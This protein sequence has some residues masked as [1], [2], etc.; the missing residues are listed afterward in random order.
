MSFV[1][2]SNSSIQNHNLSLEIIGAD[3]FVKI[4]T[5]SRESMYRFIFINNKSIAVNVFNIPFYIHDKQIGSHFFIIMI[6]H[7]KKKKIYL[8]NQ[9]DL[10]FNDI[11]KNTFAKIFERA[12]EATEY[13]FSKSDPIK[14]MSSKDKKKLSDMSFQDK[15][16]MI[17]QKVESENS[18]EKKCIVM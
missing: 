4:R 13:K 15:I 8:L 14:F 1:N 2:S 10:K 7:K 3:T 16:L 18:S 5:Y 9:H 6:F 11:L 17:N 12:L